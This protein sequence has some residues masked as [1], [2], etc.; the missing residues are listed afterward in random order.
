MK[1]P[2]PTLMRLQSAEFDTGH[3]FHLQNIDRYV[4]KEGIPSLQ[5]VEVESSANEQEILRWLQRRPYWTHLWMDHSGIVLWD[6]RADM[7]TLAKA[8]SP[9]VGRL[10]RLGFMY[11]RAH[12]FLHSAAL[13]KHTI[14]L[15]QVTSSA[16]EKLAF[17]RY[18]AS[19]VQGWWAL[20]PS[21]DPAD[22]FWIDYQNEMWILQS[23]HYRP[24]FL[25]VLAH[26][27]ALP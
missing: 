15:P 24:K 13:L 18:P 2:W 4:F 8:M 7:P 10:P 20:L 17:E 9:Q 3:M 5:N 6:P 22:R 23:L 25:D 1:V 19:L 16:H 14:D 21:L 11:Q 12:R 26:R 27:S